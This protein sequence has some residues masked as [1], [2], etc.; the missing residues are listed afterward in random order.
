MDR[1]PSKLFENEKGEPNNLKEYAAMLRH[2]YGPIEQLS[3]DTVT[4]QDQRMIDLYMKGAE[5][6]K[7][8]KV[9]NL[10]GAQSPDDTQEWLSQFPRKDQQGYQLFVTLNYLRNYGYER[11]WDMIAAACE[12]QQAPTTVNTGEDDIYGTQ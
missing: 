11:Y 2:R 3:P 12:K 5:I 9:A 7:M 1:E 4:D 8:R 10:V 6:F